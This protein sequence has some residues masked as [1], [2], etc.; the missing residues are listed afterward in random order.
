MPPK[1]VKRCPWATTPDMIAYHDAEWGVPLHD[2]AGL[3]EILGARGCAGGAELGDDLAQT[4]A[5]TGSSS[6]VS[7][8][9]SSQI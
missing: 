1:T 9:P 4:R 6:A 3:F 8:R 7:T 5:G 2:D